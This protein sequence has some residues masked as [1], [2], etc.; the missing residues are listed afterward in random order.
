MSV[1]HF[2]FAGVVTTWVLLSVRFEE[3]DLAAE[4]GEAYREYRR[5]VPM[6]LPL[7]RGSF[8]APAAP[9]LTVS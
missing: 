7:P 9:L 4:H 5:R 1:S 8:D 3:S 2:L 6:I